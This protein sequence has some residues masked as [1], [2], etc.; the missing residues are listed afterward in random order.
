MLTET[1][2]SY[3][4]VRRALGFSY[5]RAGAVLR[6]FAR[7]ADERGDTLVRTDTVVAWAGAAASL[8]ERNRRLRTVA[9][10]A[11]Y[12]HG[13][14]DRH[15]IPP[16]DLFP[17]T[18][19]RPVPYIFSPEGIGRLVAEARLLP[20]EGSLRPLTYSTLFS[21]LAATGLRIGEAL[22]LR[23]SDLIADGLVVRTTKFRKTRLVPLHDTAVAGLERYLTRRLPLNGED[24]RLLVDH[25]ARKLLYGTVN[26][27]FNK[28]ADRLGLQRGPDQPKPHLH[29]LRHTFA[30]RA[31]E[32]CPNEREHVGRHL[33]ALS[34][35]LGHS[36]IAHTYWYLEAT[37]QLLGDISRACEAFRKDVAR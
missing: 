29:S 34:T 3:V 22:A 2:S 36:S 18:R 8:G 10:F 31:L 7:F 17:H 12:V 25:R 28:L 30:V 26:N 37:P 4:A 33:L 9:R 1:V 35:Y 13:Q 14:D 24:D 16:D 20:P 5:E 19:H 27:V 32:S 21:L 6:R 23:L 11:R 15:D